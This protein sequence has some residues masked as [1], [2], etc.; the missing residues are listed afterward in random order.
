M[1]NQKNKDYARVVYND[2]EIPLTQYPK[3]LIGHLIAKYDLRSGQDLLE[4]G[5]ARGDFLKEFSNRNLS[6]S[7]VDISDYIKE[8][9]PNVNFKSANL[10]KEKI[11]F[12][13]NK[14]DIVYSKSF[15]EHFYYP[16]NIFKE[17]YRVLKPGGKVITLTPHW[18]YMYKYF[19]EDYSHRTPFTVESLN[20]IQK[21]SGFENIKTSSF[22]Q[23][24]VIWKYNFLILFAEITRI[25]SP[26]FLSK[27]LKWVRFSKEVM[28]L[29]CSQKPEKK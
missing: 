27:K 19:Y 9:C 12:E 8:Y 2:I 24:P 1:N 11:P 23:L 14:F 6:I 3:K 4:L 26:S 18:K 10:E 13:D 20:Y 29:S 5:P 15:V 21:V 25:L 28:L 7:A 17:I 22:R 16:E